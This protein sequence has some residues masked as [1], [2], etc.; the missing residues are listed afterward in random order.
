MAD[1]SNGKK[2]KTK[3]NRIGLVKHDYQGAPTT[4]CNGCGHNSISNQIISVA[5]ELGIMPEEILKFSG[6]GCSSK[7][8]TYFLGR[9]FGFNS[10]HGRMPSIATGA[11]F[12]DCTLK[13]L[14]VSGDGDTASIGMGQFKHVIRRNL[15][16][17]YIVENNG[18]YGLTKGQ[19]S[20]TAEKGL[21][22][23]Y[24]GTNPYMPIDIAWEALVGNATFVARSFAGDAKQV[25]ELLKA[26][27][28]HEGVAV[29]DIISPCVTFNNRDD[30]HHSY[31]WSRQ[32]EV[33]IHELSYVPPADE[34]TVEYRKGEA[35]E[36]T[37]HDGSHIVLKK[38]GKTH[39]PKDRTA[40][41]LLLEEANAKQELITGL[42]YIDTEQPS[43]VDIFNLPD[44]ALNRL[45]QERI[46]PAEE[47]IQKVN[48]LMF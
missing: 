47:T 36:V 44:E 10:L 16:L 35:T 3:T 29:L 39:D 18:V 31:A 14:G 33:A 32:H 17:V 24:Q 34:I 23:K 6:I 1:T 21:E 30:S 46:R 19:F 8:P 9:S 2:R 37:L 20:A 15:P 45:P 25:R 11:L 26:A 38:L 13:G 40:A 27:F 28:S 41:M 42:I 48:D 7:S 4:L 43:L 12:G 22:L 5:Y